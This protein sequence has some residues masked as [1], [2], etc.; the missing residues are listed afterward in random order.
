MRAASRGLAPSLLSILPI[1]S[2][3]SIGLL[4]AAPASATWITG[5]DVTVGAG[6]VIH[7]NLYVSGGMVTVLGTCERDV[8]VAAGTVRID[9][10]VRGDV[11]ASAGQLTL[12]GR[13][14]GDVRAMG[15]TLVVDSPV[16]GDLVLA[17][18]QVV[19]RGPVA[20]TALLSAGT[21]DVEAPIVGEAYLAGG[22]LTVDSSV[23]GPL[24]AR[25]GYLK[26]GSNAV[27]NDVDWVGDARVERAPGASVLGSVSDKLLEAPGTGSFGLRWLRRL[28]GL[29][30]LGFLWMAFFRRFV[31]GAGAALRER[32]AASFGVGL[33]VALLL[34]VLLALVTGLGALVG[35]WWLGLMGF[36]VYA[37]GAA[38]AVPLVA[39]VLGG[40]V[41]PRLR[42][43]ALERAWLSLLVSLG[44]LLF[45][46]AIP[47]VGPTL[48]FLVVSFGLGGIVL[49]L[50]DTLSH[51]RTEYQAG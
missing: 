26:L 25:G 21:V 3:L 40:F 51:T 33:L 31:G 19:V 5:E 37:M 42:V 20:G 27:V 13:F 47:W 45:A 36:A 46:F 48:A 24:T 50:R 1:L 17:G 11:L 34:P 12:T 9:G 41:A 30:V 10:E 23:E 32:A 16:P 49:A 6:E 28:V 14:G 4:A 43:P 35:G 18:G 15:G 44:V 39:L 22:Q 2:I 29:F 38:L 8:V 7:D